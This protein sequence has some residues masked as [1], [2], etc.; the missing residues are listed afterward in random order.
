MAGRIRKAARRLCRCRQS[1]RA[2]VCA[3]AVLVA[4]ATG[5]CGG[6][7][8]AP[9]VTSRASAGQ[10]SGSRQGEP[11]ATILRQSAA[12]TAGL[13]A[14]RVS[15]RISGTTIDEFMSG[16]CQSMGTVSYQG[17]VVHSVRIGGIFYFHANASFYRK[18]GIPNAMPERWRETTVQLAQRGGFLTGIDLCIGPFLH[19]WSAVTVSGSSSVTEDGIRTV[20]GQPAITLLDS[21]NDAWY[22]AAAGPPY[23][24]AVARSGGDYVNFSGFNRPVPITAPASCPPGQPAVSS[25]TP[26]VV[27]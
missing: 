5:A 7:G 16:P 10:S 15:G 24:L 25:G 17:S 9:R 4:A 27:C 6:H 20:Q 23:T 11:A 8:A 22:V 26:L 21:Q 3:F 2:A 13:R 18:A 14:V 12:A 19:Q 1:S